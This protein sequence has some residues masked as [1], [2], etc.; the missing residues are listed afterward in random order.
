MRRRDIYK[1]VRAE[2]EAHYD[3]HDRETNDTSYWLIQLADLHATAINSAAVS[4]SEGLLA[5][6]LME[7]L[8][9]SIL[10]IME[11][12]LVSRGIG[13]VIERV[14]KRG[15]TDIDT[16]LDTINQERDYQDSLPSSRTDGSEKDV[17]GY[18][19][20][21]DTY[22]RKAID[23]WTENAGPFHA[24]DMVRKLAGILVHC[25]EDLD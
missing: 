8:V 12:G 24:L 11:N 4:G 23:A 2:V 15:G 19:V 21:Y 18:L 17:Y 13:P 20:M 14:L 3:L 25:F 16:V 10:C 9:C 6:T 22:L 7:S 1:S 5:E